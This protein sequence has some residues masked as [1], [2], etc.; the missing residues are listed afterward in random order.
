MEYKPVSLTKFINFIK[1]G[2]TMIMKSKLLMSILIIVLVFSLSACGGGGNNAGS[3]GDTLRVGWTS[4]P[5]ILN[6]LTTYST[7]ALQITN[8]VYEPLLGYDTNLELSYKLAE[9]FE[10]SEDYLTLT[11]Q[12]K[13]GVKW[14]DGEPF[15]AEDVV[16]SYNIVKDNEMSDAAKYTADLESVTADGDYTVI[17][18]FSEP[19]AFNLAPTIPILPMHIWGDMTAEDIEAYSNDE[20]I[21]TGPMKF[22]SWD[23]GATVNLERNDEYYG[24]EPGPAK[25]TFIQYGN[26]D[27]MAQALKANEIDIITEVP[28]TVWEGLTDQDDINAV[29]LDSFSFHMVG[30]NCYESPDSQGNPILRDVAVRQAIN[31]AADRSNIVEVALS[32]HGAPGSVMIPDGM[33]QW[34]YQV[35]EDQL[36]DN[37]QE[38]AKK[39]LADAGYEDTNGDGVLEKDGEPLEFR[40]YAIESTTVD[41]RAAQMLRDS[42]EDIGIKLDLQT[43]DENTMGGYIFD[44]DADF[45]LFVWGWDSD[46]LD[47]GYLLGIPLTDQIG[48]DNDVFYSNPEYDELYLKQAREMNEDKRQEYLDQLQKIFYNDCGYLI[49]WYQDKLQAYRTDTWTGWEEVDG[50]IIYNV[51]YDNYV[52]VQPAE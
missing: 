33:K 10:Y 45:D 51:T 43:M 13:E 40:L 20:P 4:E 14:H 5:D 41:V 22:V 9:S 30:F 44:S 18:E 35:P 15:T 28:P 50:G 24:T 27:V 47:P 25:I 19:Q 49:L 34:Q 39:L 38:K 31:C 37:N 42:C 21:G 32:G 26:E 36:L 11:F 12:L 1:G 48:E 46:Y 23:Q 2:N 17:L 52:N 7:E 29:S 6:P 3:S 8:L 16:G